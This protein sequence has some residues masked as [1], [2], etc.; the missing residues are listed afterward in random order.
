MGEEFILEAS[1][2][3][4]AFFRI[5]SVA[6]R[7]L[8]STYSNLNMLHQFHRMAKQIISYAIIFFLV[9]GVDCRV[10]A[11]SRNSSNKEESVWLMGQL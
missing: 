3:Q 7:W 8:A 9:G 5:S 11:A 1:Y 4:T 2:Q 6:S 10:R